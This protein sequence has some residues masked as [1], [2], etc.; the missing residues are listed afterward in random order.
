MKNI[1]ALMAV[2]AIPTTSAAVMYFDDEMLHRHH[3]MRGGYR[4]TRHYVDLTSQNC[5]VR[6]AKVGGSGGHLLIFDPE[7]ENR[8][9]RH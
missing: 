9:P 1:H 3:L 8:S 2:A 6:L 7:Y 4:T 5:L